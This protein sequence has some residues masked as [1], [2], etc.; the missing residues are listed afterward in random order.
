MFI[1]IFQYNAC[2]NENT[3]KP[4]N[5]NYDEK[6]KQYDIVTQSNCIWTEGIVAYHYLFVM[7]NLIILE[8][9]LWNF[10]NP[11]TSKTYSK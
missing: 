3:C 11:S 5:Q 10:L 2:E 9:M 8:N 4:C 1:L 7:N 6:K